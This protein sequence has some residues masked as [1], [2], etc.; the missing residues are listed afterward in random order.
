MAEGTEE[1]LA[2][3]RR[4]RPRLA[5]AALV[6]ALLPLVAAIANA[7]LFRDA[8][9]AAYL[10]ALD[11]A[12]RPGP[13]EG[14]PSLRAPRFE[15]YDDRFGALIAT[16]LA[17]V[18]GF[19][20]IAW[21]LT[22][23]ARATRARRPE[24]PK[25]A[26]YLGLVG[27]VLTAVATILNTIASN[28]AFNDFL[29]GP[30]TL[31]EAGELGRGSL[32]ITAQLIGFPGTLALGLA[33]VLIALNAMRAGLLTRFMGVLGVI[34]GVLVVIPLG[35]PLPIVQTFWLFAL[36]VLLLGR[37]PGGDLPA[38]RTGR[39]EAWPSQQEVRAA[40]QRELARRRGQPEPGA[41]GDA[42]DTH[43]AAVAAGDEEGGPRRRKRKRRDG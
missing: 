8:P 21:V 42:D 20:A 14:L 5:L 9:R 26:L 36:A 27:G 40:R 4:E 32:A 13:V 25:I 3:E 1:Q 31:R 35:S 38:W 34:V 12:L 19:L 16:S 24:L 10:D 7:I 33:F 15:F 17:S 41:G 28:Q 37:W 22:F 39:A 18:L 2:Y 30:R 43:V 29:S 6:A 23:L 11:R